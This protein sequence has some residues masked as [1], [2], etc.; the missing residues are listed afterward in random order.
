[1]VKAPID[2]GTLAELWQRERRCHEERYAKEM[3]TLSQRER[4]EAG[5]ALRRLSVDEMDATAGGRFL[6]WLSSAKP[7]D[8]ERFALQAGEP[9]RLWLRTPSG[10][11]RGTLA[12]KSGAR[13]GVIA[14]EDLPDELFE[15]EFHLDRDAP[16]TTFERGDAAIAR[17]R[18]IANT[19]GERVGLRD[20]VLGLRAPKS[21]DLETPPPI[22]ADLHE[23]QQNAVIGA[24]ASQDIGLVLGPPGTGKTRTLVEVIRQLVRRGDRVLATAASNA[25]VD[26]LGERLAAS[27]TDVV[28]LGHP[29][30]VS[31]ALE[32]RRLDVLLR[33]SEEAAV[34]RR[35]LDQ[36]G[37]IRR[38]AEARRA[39][40]RLSRRELR[41]RLRE[42]RALSREARDHLARGEAA[43]VRHARVICATAAG[44]DAAA[45]GDTHF[46]WVV[47]DEAT[48]APDPIAL[49]ALSRAPRAVLAGDPHQLP[50]T[51]IDPRAAAEGLGRTLFEALADA[52]PDAPRMLVRQH[53]MNAEIMAFPSQ[54]KY[55]GQLEASPE[56]AAHALADLGVAEDPLRPGPWHFIDTAGTGWSEERGEDEPSLANPGQAERVAAEVRRVLSRGVSPEQ[57]AVIAAYRAQVRRLRERLAG[58][59]E[60]GLEIAT[61]DAFQGRESEVVV[62]DLVRSN[63]RGEVGFLADT[64]RMNVAL[65][66][67]KRLLIVVGDSATVG[68]HPYYAEF[69]AHA[70]SAGAHLSAW[71]D[72]AEP[73]CSPDAP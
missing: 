39:R 64:R 21:E 4:V 57:I 23:A 29:A 22:D 36:A 37:E 10:G 16:K 69:L 9:V 7:R 43:L 61:V 49:V 45:L 58:E 71:A 26:N 5:T 24:L 66:R 56:V 50:P 2:L 70:E 41:D 62:V 12:R 27:G 3:E 73:L 14:D 8:L 6:L 67:A 17:F 54:T 11:V 34:A 44:A 55:G 25:A 18:R 33:R 60:R 31:P 15:E 1:M 38:R 35:W 20:V 30:R 52:Y 63:D 65:T 72:A 19:P 32:A 28:R 68:N 59:R 48:Q 13:V 47:L 46:D 51:V 40:G 42:A 53:R